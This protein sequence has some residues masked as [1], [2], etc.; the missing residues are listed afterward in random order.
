M[1]RR[2]S[3]SRLFVL[4]RRPIFSRSFSVSFPRLADDSNQSPVSSSS[5]GPVSNPK[6]VP[7]KSEQKTSAATAQ[8]PV[9]QKSND[10]VDPKAVGQ[11]QVK[12]SNDKRNG[13][14]NNLFQDKKFNG[15]S[16]ETQDRIFYGQ[17]YQGKGKRQ[18]QSIQPSQ[19][20][21][22]Y[23]NRNRKV[24]GAPKSSAASGA[25]SQSKSSAPS[26]KKSDKDIL[27]TIDNLSKSSS[28]HSPRVR[29]A[30]PSYTAPSTPLSELFSSPEYITTPLTAQDI[31]KIR[32]KIGGEYSHVLSFGGSTQVDEFVKK[33]KVNDKHQDF[34]SELVK[35]MAMVLDQNRS[36]A[37]R[38]SKM[39]VV[40]K[41]LEGV[42]PETRGNLEK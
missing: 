21:R 34:A 16:G 28:S 6:N 27:N 36:I 20:D 32:E 3:V 42:W 9:S 14:D 2:S 40:G 17:K 15:K 12:I 33:A 41:V 38:D 1:L 19:P 10:V 26:S 35:T 22:P 39:K 31:V 11:K 8:N 23:Y 13:N 29:T 4:S 18:S 24:T 30:F 25:S 7:L 37:D 5:K